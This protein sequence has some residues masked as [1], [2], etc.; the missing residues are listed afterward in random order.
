ME[1]FTPPGKESHG[2][3]I[4]C[5]Q[6]QDTGSRVRTSLLICDPALA[7]T[8]PYCLVAELLSCAGRDWY[9]LKSHMCLGPSSIL[10]EVKK[11]G[12]WW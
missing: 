1:L 4:M 8:G 5:L 9:K 12:G 6:R 10:V 3:G 11:G 7:S 2:A